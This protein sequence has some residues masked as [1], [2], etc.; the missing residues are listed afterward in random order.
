MELKEKVIL[1]TGSSSGIGKA[2]AIEASK[3]GARILVHYRQN[4]KGAKETLNWVEKFSSGKIY[5]ADLSNQYATEELFADIKKAGFTIDALVNNAGESASGELDDLDKWEQQFQNIFYSAVYA[6]NS[7]LKHHSQKTLRKIV[8]VSSI[9]GLPEMANPAFPQYSAAKSALNNFTL[10]LA[11]TLAP[12]VLVNAVAP[13]FTWTPSWEGTSQKT[14]EAIK[15]VTKIKR[16]IEPE[17]IATIVVELL[18]NDAITGE[19]IRVDGGLHL[20]NVR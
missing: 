10:N 19:I 7:F 16:F 15:N 8:N 9:Y 2:I 17:E 14:I 20:V 18:R 13:G 1:V 5:Q 6:V 4:K 3:A 12:N 11:K